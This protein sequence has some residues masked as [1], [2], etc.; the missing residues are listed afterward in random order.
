TPE[1][2]GM[3][4]AESIAKMKKGVRII[5]AAR[6]A[7]INDADL[8]EAI[9]SGHVTGAALDVY[10]SEP[11][12]ADH[13]LVGLKNVIDRPHLADR[14]RDAQIN[15]GIEAAQLVLDAL[16]NGSYQNVCNPDVQQKLP[17]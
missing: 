13:P 1:T 8:A 16:T 17:G 5:N 6:G 9:K 7:L 10:E 12:P 11:P 4:N 15:V 3:I 2:R 14:T